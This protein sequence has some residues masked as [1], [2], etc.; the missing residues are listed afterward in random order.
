[1]KHLLLS[2]FFLAAVG[3]G[4]PAEKSTTTSTSSVKPAP[5]QPI[6]P[7][8]A[9]NPQGCPEQFY[10]YNQEKISLKIK[11]HFIIVGFQPGTSAETRTRILKQF[12]EYEVASGEQKTDVTPFLVVKLKAG[13]TCSQTMP[14]LTKLQ[15]QAEV[16]YANPVF[17]APTPLGAG[18]AWI[19]LTSEFLVN[20]KGAGSAAELKALAAKTNTK[21]VD[22]LGET[23]F[24]LQATK[25]SQG[26]ALDMANLFHD[27]AFV[28][29]AEPDFYMAAQS[30]GLQQK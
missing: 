15:S 26:N 23:T 21:I 13:T 8:S 20:I 14:M 22:E 28:S 4:K 3:C 27:Q 17:N 16:L 24:L 25:T 11:P 1:M 10:Y 18:T 9:A 2:L 19:G 30:G 12:P 5:A 29:S 7:A 6:E